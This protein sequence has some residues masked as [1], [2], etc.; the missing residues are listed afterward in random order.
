ME[1]EE[2]RLSS[3]AG[4]AIA[5]NV[6]TNKVDEKIRLMSTLVLINIFLIIVWLYLLT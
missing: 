5:N 3:A 2:A 6:R 4:F 1:D